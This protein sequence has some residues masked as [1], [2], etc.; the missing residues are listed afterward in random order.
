[1]INSLGVR[2]RI[3]QCHTTHFF[4]VV[5]GVYQCDDIGEM[6]LYHFHHVR[7]VKGVAQMQDS[8]HD[9]DHQYI[10]QTPFAQYRKIGQCPLSTWT[11]RIGCEPGEVQQNQFQMGPDPG[12]EEQS[13]RGQSGKEQSRHVFGVP[14]FLHGVHVR[15][16]PYDPNLIRYLV[17]IGSGYVQGVQCEFCLVRGGLILDIDI[18]VQ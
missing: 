7:E 10:D 12:E 15:E 14:Q 16:G 9:T 8:H 4:I 13:G 1:M 3:L 6:R 5:E 2:T 11:I 17:V 18:G